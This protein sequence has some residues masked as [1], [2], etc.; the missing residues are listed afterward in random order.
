MLPTDEGLA[1]K[2]YAFSIAV[3]YQDGTQQTIPLT[4]TAHQ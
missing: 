1:G 2:S 3:A 4:L